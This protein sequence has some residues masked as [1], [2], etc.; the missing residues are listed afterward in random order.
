M[1]ISTPAYRSLAEK[2][3]I[4]RDDCCSQEPKIRLLM[5]LPAPEMWP[6]FQKWGEMS[7]PGPCVAQCTVTAAES[8]AAP[9]LLFKAW[10]VAIAQV[11]HTENPTALSL[12]DFTCRAGSSVANLFTHLASSNLFSLTK[13]SDHPFQV[14]LLSNMAHYYFMVYSADK[15]MASC[16]CQHQLMG[17][18]LF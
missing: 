7:K 18:S 11:C 2:L 3:S 9:D 13:M 8:A 12:G 17:I 10:S 4:Y 1:Q 5:P 6:G 14:L 15:I 16:I